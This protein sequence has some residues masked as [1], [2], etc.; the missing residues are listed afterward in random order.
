VNS[1]EFF[2]ALYLILGFAFFQ[3]VSG[4]PMPPAMEVANAPVVQA[5]LLSNTAVAAPGESIELGVQLKMAPGW[6]T[7]YKDAG[8][9]GLPTKVEW[10]LPDGAVAQNLVWPEPEKFVES[11]ITTY[12]YKESCLLK[13]TVKLPA[14]LSGKSLLLGAKVSWL[15]CKDICLPGKAA[16]SLRLPVAEHSLPSA[17]EKLFQQQARES[18][19]ISNHQEQAKFSVLNSN[20]EAS[21]ANADKSLFYYFGFALLGGFILNFMPCVLPVIAIKV[22]SF[23]EDADKEPARVRLQGLAFASGIISSFLALALLVAVIKAAGQ[24]VGWGFQFQY[25][26]FVMLMSLLILVMSLSFFGLFYINLGGVAGGGLNKLAQQEGNLG[27]FFKGVLATVLSTPCTAPF[28]GSALGF[29]FAQSM[30]TIVLIFFASGVGMAFPYLLLA[31]RPQW[32]KV[33]PKPGLWMDKLK[34]ALGFVL[35]ATVVWLSSQVLVNQVGP[36]VAANFQYFLVV[37]ALAVWIIGNF[38]DLSSSTGAKV[39]IYALA[40]SLVFLAGWFLLLGSPLFWR[41]LKPE[42]AVEKVQPVEDELFVPFSAQALDQALAE[43]NTVFLDFTADWCQTCKA[44]ERLV[45]QDKAVERALRAKGILCFKADWTRQDPIISKLLGKFGRAGVPLYVIF[46][47]RA[48][49]KPIILPE[50]ITPAL[51]LEKL[52]EAQAI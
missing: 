30:G 22:M 6:H 31:I 3:P 32:L 5:Q 34:Q 42:A 38:T 24:T 33:L 19:P 7:Y 51:V 28:L 48:P 10:S 50:V 23:L 47:A 44:N 18:K 11:G 45:L 15:A 29:A 40:L 41:A 20:F 4:E 26:G 49:E 36:Q 1:R 21:G 43:G 37:V 39:K 46:P 14:S 52:A 27:S 12:G 9:A 16:L 2:I 25:P 8:D 35:L 17:Q 13:S